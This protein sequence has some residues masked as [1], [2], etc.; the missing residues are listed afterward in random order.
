MPPKT[1]DRTAGEKLLSLYTLLLLQADRPISLSSLAKA[2][3]CSKQTVLRL[4]AQLEASGYGKLEEPIRKGREHFYRLAQTR[5]GLLNLGAR[6]LSLLA[7]CRNVLL[8]LLPRNGFLA[9]SGQKGDGLRDSELNIFYKG[10]VDYAPY[11][12]QYDKI[13]QAIKKRIVCQVSYRKS[14]FQPVREFCFAPMRI[15][16]YR[17]TLSVAG[18]EVNMEGPAESLYSNWLWLYIQRL[19]SV[20]LTH[21]SSARLPDIDLQN[22]AGFGLMEGEPFQVRLRFSASAANYVRDRQWAA[23]QNMIITDDRALILEMTARNTP[24]ILA[25]ILSFGTS[26]TV[27]EPEWLKE[28]VASTA[29]AIARQNSE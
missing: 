9:E 3:V 20:K 17:E 5:A 23:D 7:L 12:E 13:Q 28:E 27:L 14:I 11:E 1:S 21:R 29:L 25:W 22:N 6:E 26:V 16:I 10:Y 18:W 24:E 19:C 2:L 8:N 4:L 15:F